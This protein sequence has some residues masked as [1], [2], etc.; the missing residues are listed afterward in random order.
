LYT[1][2]ESAKMDWIALNSRRAGR[3]LQ[4]S[5]LQTRVVETESEMRAAVVTH[6][7]E[8]AALNA[9][10][11]KELAG[12]RRDQDQRISAAIEKRSADVCDR[13]SGIWSELNTARAALLNHTHEIATLK[14]THKK[15]LAGVQ[16]EHAQLGNVIIEA[17]RAARRAETCDRSSVLRAELHTARAALGQQTAAAACRGG[18]E[19][20]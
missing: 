19:R 12:A 6:D 17:E 18:D 14:A 15:E 1:E 2:L 3:E 8:I 4:T 10:H 5:N 16:K 9:A 13:A 11:K 20:G 7:N